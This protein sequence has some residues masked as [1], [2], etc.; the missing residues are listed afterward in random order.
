LGRLVYNICLYFCGLQIKK[1]INQSINQLRYN[2]IKHINRLI[3]IHK[4]STQFGIDY[5][6]EQIT[7]RLLASKNCK[8]D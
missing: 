3:I 8:S 2:Q 1:S 7:T 6:F 5:T 4:M